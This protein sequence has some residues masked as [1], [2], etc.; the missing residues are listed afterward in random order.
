[1]KLILSGIEL[2]GVGQAND[3]TFNKSN[4]IIFDVEK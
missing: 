2:L 1:M 3:F 4:I